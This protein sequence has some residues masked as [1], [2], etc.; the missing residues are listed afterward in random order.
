MLRRNLVANYIGQSCA[1]LLGI[2]FVPLY[3]RYLGIEAYGLIGLFSVLNVALSLLDLG[4][5]PALSRQMA[6]F[7][8]GG[9]T[10][11]SIRDLLRSVEI[12]LF[13]VAILVVLGVWAGSDWIAHSWLQPDGLARNE[14]SDAVAVIGFVAAMRLFEGIYRSSLVGLQRQVALNV[15]VV[16]SSVLRGVGAI[17]VLAWLS[18]TIWA[19]FVWQ[20]LVSVL[21]VLA[22]ALTAYL[23]LPMS[24]RG[25]RFSLLALRSQWR[26]SGGMLSITVLSVLLTQVDK[27]LL[28]RLLTLGEYGYY[29]LA[30]ATAGGVI[31]LVVPIAQAW[32]PRM[33]QLLVNPDT[34][35]LIRTFHQG[36][37]LVNVVAGSMA[38]VLIFFAE[39]FLHLWTQDALLAS[40]TAPLLSLL[41]AGNLLNAQMWIPFQLQLAHGWTGL[42]VRI[43]AITV[44]LLV[45][46]VLVVTPRYGAEGAAW[47]WITLNAGYVF[48]G[49]H[50][51]YQRILGGERWKWFLD[52]LFK[53]L[54]AAACVVGLLRLALPVPANMT[55]ELAELLVASV[56]AVLAAIVAAGALMPIVKHHLQRRLS[57]V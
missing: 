19:F 3:I 31:I 7:T 21:T 26:F 11:V 24:Y 37:Q 34:P 49:I 22:F 32:F 10:A 38:L 52:D 28:S 51:M 17:A 23:Y 44:L 5:A 15:V 57:S 9:H 2:V 8:S 30:A 27:M 45:P 25:G 48:I 53:P 1:A 43:N 40:R 41:L 14:V 13:M 16:A 42:A 54:F 36:A 55:A 6:R 12:F 56:G 50:F 39:T 20:G 46:A 4:M 47:V 35:A 18:P 33:S 29:T